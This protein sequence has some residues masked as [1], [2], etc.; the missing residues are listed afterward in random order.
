MKGSSRLSIK[1]V[2][3]CM[4]GGVQKKPR[5]E[6]SYHNDSSTAGSAR[7]FPGKAGLEK[8]RRSDRVEPV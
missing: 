6:G 2:K 4:H 8:E 1:G 5:G 3:T 7:V